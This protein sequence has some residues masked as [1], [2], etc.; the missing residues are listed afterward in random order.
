MKTTKKQENKKAAYVTE[1]K[2]YHSEKILDKFAAALIEAKAEVRAD[3]ENGTARVKISDRNSKMG[4]IPSISTLPFFTC[5][6]VCK[7]T[8]APSC[9]AAKLANLRPAVL[10]AYAYNTALYLLNQDAYFEQIAE[11]TQGCRFF[12]WH[13]SG[14]IVNASYFAEMVKI[15]GNTPH[16]DF[17]A[18]TKSFKIVND[19]ISSNG[20]LPENLHVI[21]SGWTNMTPENPHGLPETTVYIKEEDFDAERWL[22]CGGNC[23]HCACRGLGC[24]KA[25]SG[26]IIAFKKH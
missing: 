23:F 13:V 22:S 7:G 26:D 8:C 20:A 25:Q 9:Y 3:L 18:F 24:W 19:W 15:A 12:R 16:C 4:E 11:F 1:Y 5:P 21:F 17:L 10:H 6:A 2:G 14:D